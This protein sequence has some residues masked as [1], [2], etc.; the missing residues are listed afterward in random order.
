MLEKK[1]DTD[2][3]GALSSELKLRQKIKSPDGRVGI[4]K[5]EFHA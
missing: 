2:G 5:E 4:E 1:W 3:K